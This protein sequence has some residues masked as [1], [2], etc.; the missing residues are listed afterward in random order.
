MVI[1]G[2]QDSCDRSVECTVEV[3]TLLMNTDTQVTCLETQR[4]KYIHTYTENKSTHM[5]NT[6]TR[7]PKYMHVYCT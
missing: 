1:R 6:C 4:T 7:R 2:Q 5:K 3:A